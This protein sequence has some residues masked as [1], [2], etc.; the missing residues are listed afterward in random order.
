MKRQLVSI[1]TASYNYEDYIKETIESIINQSYTNWELIIVDDGSKDNSIEVIQEY[2]KKDSRIKLF[3]HPNNENKGLAETVK[4][5]L[6]NASGEWIAFLE[7]DDIFYPTAIEEKIKVVSEN[8]K[9]KFI[10]SDVEMFGDEEDIEY[11]NN[12]FYIKHSKAL[13]KGKPFRDFA[14]SFIKKN[15]IYTFSIVMTTKEILK[16]CDFNSPVTSLLDHYLWSQIAVENKFY[17]LDKK[18]TKWRRHKSSYIHKKIEN[19]EIFIDAISHNLKKRKSFK[20]SIL[21]LLE[22]I[23]HSKQKLISIKIGKN[24]YLKLFGKSILGK[25]T[26]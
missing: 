3:T 12:K 7:S 24:G 23:K 8:P 18:L 2:C 14:P 13:K 19:F 5:G 1:I 16:Q 10:F 26:N 25:T 15:M 11:A 17:Y 20:I 4:L 21:L 22:R 9:V 6:E